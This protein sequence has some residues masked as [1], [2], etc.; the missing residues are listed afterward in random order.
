MNIGLLNILI[1]QLTITYDKLTADKEAFAMK[2]RWSSMGGG[3]G[4]N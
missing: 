4:E 1:A 3:E 2:H